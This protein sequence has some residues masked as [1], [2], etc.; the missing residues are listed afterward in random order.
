MK[1]LTL[2]RRDTFFF[3]IDLVTFK[4]YLIVRRG[5]AAK[6]FHLDIPLDT[7]ND[8][9]GVGS[10]LGSLVELSHNND[11]LTS[12]SAS[13]DNGDLSGLVDWEVSRVRSRDST[14][15]SESSVLCCSPFLLPVSWSTLALIMAVV[16]PSSC[17]IQDLM[18]SRLLGNSL[19]SSSVSN[20]LSAFSFRYSL[21][22]QQS[23][24]RLERAFDRGFG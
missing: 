6:R 20:L 22:L 19:L 21:P 8:G 24:A 15:L 14:K 10:L 9:V 18:P 3:P 2:D 16:L 17:D 4:G 7:G 11:L 12:L 5:T 23:T 1:G 13:K